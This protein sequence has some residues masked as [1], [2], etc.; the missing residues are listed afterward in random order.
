[1]PP[2]NCVDASSC[3]AAK[4]KEDASPKADSD[5]VCVNYKST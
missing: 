1:M 5:N 2:L 3:W 4:L